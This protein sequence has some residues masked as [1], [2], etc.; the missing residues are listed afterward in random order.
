MI[1]KKMFES[2]FSRYL[3]YF[4]GTSNFFFQYIK[5]NFNACISKISV[6]CKVLNLHLKQTPAKHVNVLTMISNL[7]YEEDFY[8]S[9]T[10]Q[11][12]TTDYKKEVG[13]LK[14]IAVF[15]VLRW[16]L[17]FGGLLHDCLEI[18]MFSVVCFLLHH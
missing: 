11:P 10:I 13:Y 17:L 3:S 7:I 5:P 14:I 4:Q 16:L 8:D 1:Q 18:E 12:I 2:K 9:F 6:P 15:G